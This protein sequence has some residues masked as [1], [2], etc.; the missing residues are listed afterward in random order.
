M[1]SWGAVVVI[2]GGPE[3]LLEIGGFG[4]AEAAGTF[5]AAVSVVVFGGKAFWFL[6]VGV[7]AAVPSKG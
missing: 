1:V 6:E 7:A 4:A 3:G 5:R 2:P